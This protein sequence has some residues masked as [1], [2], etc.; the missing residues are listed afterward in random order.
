MFVKVKIKALFFC[1]WFSY[2]VCF[3]QK[4]NNQWRFSGQGGISF[5]PA[6]GPVSVGKSA[7]SAFEG[8]ATVANRT[9][10][11]LLFYTDGVTVW[12]AQDDT[13]QG[14]AGLLGGSVALSSTTAAVIVP[15]P[16]QPDWY[17]IFTIDEQNAN[18]GIRYSVVDMRLN[19]G[20]GA[21]L[22]AQKNI[23]LYSTTSEKLEVVPA[24]NG[25]DLWL[26]SHETPGSTLL[27][28][29]ISSN[30]ISPPVKSE[31]GG[32]QVNGAG[33]LKVNRQFNKIA[34]GNFFDQSIELFDFNNETGIFSNGMSVKLPN[35]QLVYGVEFSPDGSLLYVSNLESIYQLN[36]KLSSSTEITAAVYT[37]ATGS[38]LATLQLGPDDKIYVN[39]GS[40]IAAINC[41][42]K[43]GLSCNYQSSP[44]SNFTGGGGWGLPKWVY[45]AEDSP[46]VAETKIIYADSCA[47][48]LLRFSL[49]SSSNIS[50]VIWNFG[51]GSMPVK[52]GI[53]TAHTYTNAGTYQVMAVLTTPCGIDTIEIPQ[54]RVVNCDFTK[55]PF[56]IKV[57][58]DTCTLNAPVAF[59]ITDSSASLRLKWSFQESLGG[60]ADTL[61]VESGNVNRAV[62]YAFNQKGAYKVCV[63][64]SNSIPNDTVICITINAGQCCDDVSINVSDSC[65]G[66][67]IRFEVSKSNGVSNIL[68]RFNNADNS[69]SNMLSPTY[70]YTEGGQYLIS[71]VL[72]GTCGKDTLNKLITIVLCDTAKQ[73]CDLFIPN[74][75]TP[76]ADG[77]NDLF[78]VTTT[79]S[80]SETF[81]RVF[82]RW[83]SVAF[84]TRDLSKPWNGFYGQEICPDGVYFYQLSF[85]NNNDVS[86]T[87][88]GTITLIR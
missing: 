26:L 45:Y 62:T 8:I 19:N 78:V 35:N 14:G 75:F 38:S 30:G 9:T 20:L 10:G 3:A 16:Q 1:F 5:A 11:E 58:G 51:D 17:Y 82:N 4:Q 72:D 49:E 44:I 59:V 23:F 40:G 46:K 67:P 64:V 57:D 76:N 7:L 28:F 74:V 50:G 13:M 81:L 86:V 6:N 66:K 70:V 71:A 33:H 84:E 53:N 18:N 29:R 68:W 39:P 27:A 25:K 63:V 80:V 73:N 32:Y 21:I 56:A 88:R 34:L 48:K 43:V 12:N 87:R 77:I 54:F 42:N 37:V 15:Y 36:L 24:G 60:K 65:L 85:K 55:P 69:T 41:P 83:G 79:C 61:I 52:D 2:F 31:I 47:G 22:T